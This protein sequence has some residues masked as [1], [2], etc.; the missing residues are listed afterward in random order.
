MQRSIII[1]ERCGER[2]L[3]E[4]YMMELPVQVI[5]DWVEG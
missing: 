2:V 1:V 4:G 3:W 5:A